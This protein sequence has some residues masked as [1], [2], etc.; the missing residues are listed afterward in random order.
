MPII[1]SCNGVDKSYTEVVTVKK[2]LKD[3]YPTHTS[4]FV[5]G[6][7]DNKLVALNTIISKNSTIVMIDDSN[8]KF[9]SQVKRSCIQLLHRVLKEIWS[10]VK[11]ANSCITD[12]GFF[13]DIDMSYILKKQDLQK[14]S[15]KMLK[16]ISTEYKIFVKNIS[17][18]DFLDFLNKNNETYQIDIFREKCKKKNAVDVCYHEDYC[19]FHD[20]SQVSNIKFC[21]YFILQDVSG[22]YW[23][24]NKNN[25][26]LQR[27]HAIV[28]TSKYQLLRFLSVLEELKKRDHRK[29]AKLLD[30]Y[31]IQKDSPGMIFWHK[32]GYIIFRQLEQFIRDH[33]VRHNYEEVKSPIIIDKSLW[34]K[35]GHWEYYNASI[36]VTKSE[37]R[38]FCIKP[39]NCPAH[40][41]IFKNKLQSYKDLPIR[42][43]EFG[44]CHRQ[45]SSGSLHGLMRVRGF[46]QDDAHIFCTQKQIKKELNNCIHLLLDL[47]NT[48]G[49]K[50]VIIKV[51]TRPVKRIGSEKTWNQAEEDLEY[52]LKKNNLPFQ[53][54]VGEGAFYGPKIEIA[55]EDTLQRIWQ[56]GTIQLD[57]YLAQKLNA[58]YINKNNIKKKPII[59]HRALLGSI[60]RFI[61]ILLEEF[62]GKLPIWLCPVQVIVISVST[63]HTLYVQKMVQKLLLHDIRVIFDTT[64]T[65]IGLKIRSSI[66]QNIPYILICGDKEI[67]NKY[68]TIRNRFSNKQC[69]STIDS[70]IKNI[71]NNIKNRSIQDFIMEG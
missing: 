25:K 62:S 47:Y 69:K 32:N 57:F 3:I 8:Q 1:I 55:L 29:I 20:H 7:V 66:I 6:L 27:I 64:N 13:C 45:E 67:Q 18:S 65:S 19:E 21:R 46:T 10:D 4:S 26:M 33:L 41:Q 51:S 22:A 60:E 30:L 49:F 31:H 2:I 36:F 24:N 38:E 43:S 9:L 11:I 56:C 59:I 53:Y 23:D 44:S 12:V 63:S 52:V 34:E 5:A 42:I 15:K 37:N 71:K 40:V 28:C 70:F 58:F 68:I 50:K 39:M 54:Q 48:F 17:I 61:G 16:K 35:S 14:I